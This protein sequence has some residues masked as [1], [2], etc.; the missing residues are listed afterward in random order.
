MLVVATAA[1]LTVTMKVLKCIVERI[2]ARR[3]VKLKIADHYSFQDRQTLLFKCSSLVL[4]A[5]WSRATKGELRQLL[6]GQDPIASISVDCSILQS[7]LLTLVVESV[8][9]QAYRL[10]FVQDRQLLIHGIYWLQLISH[11]KSAL[12]CEL[13]E[14]T[15]T[16]F[17]WPRSI[18]GRLTYHLE[19]SSRA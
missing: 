13:R 9:V 17:L 10:L 12:N 2:N 3:R 8:R 4:N 7:C 16:M 6:Y 5:R 11:T 1:M 14:D 18:Y 19:T 15:H